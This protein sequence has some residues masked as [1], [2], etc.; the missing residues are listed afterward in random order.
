MSTS[1]RGMYWTGG[2]A[3]SRSVSALRVS[4]NTRPATDTTTRAWLRSIVIGCSGPGS[5][6]ALLSMVLHSCRSVDE[7]KFAPD[8]GQAARRRFLPLRSG[9][10]RNSHAAVLRLVIYWPV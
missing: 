5:L 10:A 1:L 9:G 2:S 7:D 3:A 8:A 6:I 4:G